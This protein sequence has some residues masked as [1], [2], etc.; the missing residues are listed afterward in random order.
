[1]DFSYDI[2]ARTV[3][4]EPKIGEILSAIY[5][6]G[7]RRM[8][9]MGYFYGHMEAD[10]ETMLKARTRLMEAGFSVGAI[11]LP[12]GHPGN[13]LNPDDPDLELALPGHWQYRQ[14]E[15]GREVYYCGCV[16]E[17]LVRDNRQAMRDLA[18][19]GFERVFFDDDLRMGNAGQAIEGCFCPHCLREFSE[20]LGENI[21]RMQLKA[22]IHQSDAFKNPLVQ[23]WMDYNCQ[24]IVDFLSKMRTPGID[25]GI[26]VMY[27]GDRRH[28]LDIPAMLKVVPDLMIRVGE[29]HFCDADF[30]RSG[31][32]EEIAQS[33]AL[34]SGLVERKDLLYSESTIFPARALSKENWIERMRLEIDCGL[35]H[36]FLM[37]GTWLIEQDYWQALSNARQELL[38]RAARL[39]EQMN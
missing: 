17:A 38:D 21:S 19:M 24:K 10:A 20:H 35:R 25:L 7:V 5:R 3:M 26:M 16:N 27:K 6:A 33:I 8:E 4:E 9:L 37:S 1:M 18:Q 22:C 15:D 31:G 32:K 23:A 30:E 28:G 14:D 2:S 11:N 12:V 39:D 36:L 13:S 34:H 29:G